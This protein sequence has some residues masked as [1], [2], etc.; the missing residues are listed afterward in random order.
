MWEGNRRPREGLEARVRRKA[1]S[2]GGRTVT[3]A[4][5]GQ[6]RAGPPQRPPETIAE[7]AKSER[8]GAAKARRKKRPPRAAKNLETRGGRLGA[9]PEKRSNQP[10]QR[11]GLEAG[12]TPG[13]TARPAAGDPQKGQRRANRREANRKGQQ[14]DQQKSG[15]RNRRSPTENFYS[16]RAGGVQIPIQHALNGS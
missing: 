4:A 13:P 2:G 1:R 15:R 5:A 16:F 8:P 9:P 11:R 3:R 7:T 14:R 12:P 6:A 10:G